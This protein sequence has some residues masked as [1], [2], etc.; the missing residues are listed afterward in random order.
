MKNTNFAKACVRGD[1]NHAGIWGNVTFSKRRRGVLV[2]AHIFGLPR[3][4]FFAFHIHEGKS[5]AGEG[6]P[7]SGGHYNPGDEPHPMHAGDLPPLLSC[8]GEAYLQVLTNRFGIC[9]VIGRTVII[10]SDP[11]DFHTQPSGNSGEKIACGKIV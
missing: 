10:H 6:F 3:D 4:G 1:E 11:D 8:G 2:T 9:E 5:C 7:Q